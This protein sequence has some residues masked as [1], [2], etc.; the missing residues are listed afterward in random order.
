MTKLIRKIGLTLLLLISFATAYSQTSV[1]D[2]GTAMGSGNVGAVARCFD[3]AITMNIAGKQSTYSR[4]QA[5][6]ILRDFFSKHNPRGFD[7]EY[8]NGNSMSKYAIGT[9]FTANGEYR[10]YFTVRQRDNT[11]VIQEIRFE[12]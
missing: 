3:N 2:I 5:E 6:M 1:E 10:T 7:L 4:S 12:K 8:S 11:Y 9:L